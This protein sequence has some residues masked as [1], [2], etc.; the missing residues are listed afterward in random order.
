MAG[1]KYIIIFTAHNSRVYTCTY[2][3]VWVRK[4]IIFRFLVAITLYL[5][6]NRKERSIAL[7]AVVTAARLSA[8]IQ[9]GLVSEVI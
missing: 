7:E 3:T 1:E 4:L 2:G 5:F 8:E 9:K 6:I